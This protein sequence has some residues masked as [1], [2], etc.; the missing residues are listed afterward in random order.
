MI[1][2]RSIH[3]VVKK[4]HYRKTYGKN[5]IHLIAFYL[6]V[7]VSSLIVLSLCVCMR[8]CICVCVC[9]HK[10]DGVSDKMLGKIF[11]FGT[12]SYPAGFDLI[13]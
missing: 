2:K 13:F 3:A 5:I 11:W 8:A 12:N 6:I 7:M 10:A 9:S 4:A 1:L